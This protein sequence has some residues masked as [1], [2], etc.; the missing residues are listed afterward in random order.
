MKKSKRTINQIK[1]TSKA[2]Q[3]SFSLLY[4]NG[5]KLTESIVSMKYIIYI[6]TKI[7]I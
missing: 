6:N 7:M 1:S 4:K 2:I 3:N 5:E